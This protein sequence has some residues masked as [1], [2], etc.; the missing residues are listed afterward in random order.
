MLAEHCT[1]AGRYVGRSVRRERQGVA[2]RTRRR[3][4]LRFGAMADY[5]RPGVV[6][7][8]Q[9]EMVDRIGQYV[10]RADQ[11]NIAMRA[12]WD[13]ASLDHLAGAIDEL[14]R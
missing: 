6:M 11:V 8:S 3:F 5:V 12:P 7:G 2:P 1:A 14:G 9:A 10:G 13:V 4:R